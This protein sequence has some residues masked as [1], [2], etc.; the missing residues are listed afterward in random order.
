MARRTSTPQETAG[1]HVA[2]TEK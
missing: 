2:Y 1:V